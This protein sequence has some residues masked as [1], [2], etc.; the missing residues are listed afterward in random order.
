MR[1]PLTSADLPSSTVDAFSA[2]D[3]LDLKVG[4]SYS[5]SGQPY[6]YVANGNSSIIKSPKLN[7]NQ[8]DR[9]HYLHSILIAANSLAVNYVL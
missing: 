7:S 1:V 9:T 5:G 2:Y 8:L 3:K 4:G 6:A